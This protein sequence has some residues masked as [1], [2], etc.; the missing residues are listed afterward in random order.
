MMTTRTLPRV[1]NTKKLEK[2]A[3]MAGNQASDIHTTMARKPHEW[4]Q[5]SGVIPYRLVV[6]ANSRQPAIEVLLI[7]SR[8]RKRWVIPKGIVEPDMSPQESAVKEALEEAGIEGQVSETPIGMYLYP[9]W[10]GI[11]RVDVFPFEVATILSDWEEAEQR[12]REWVSLEE[13]AHRVWEDE[14]KTLFRKLP[15]VISIVKT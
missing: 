8:K 12:S 13:A 9:K 7:T 4:Y 1:E 2:T 14:L 6:S 11:C 5:Q 15:Q 10:N 3:N